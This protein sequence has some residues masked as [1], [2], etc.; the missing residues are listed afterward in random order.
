MKPIGILLMGLI[1]VYQ[2]TLA[3][4]LGANCRFEPSCSDYACR[5][6]HVHGAGR[7]SWLAIRRLARC[8]PWGAWGYDPVPEHPAGAKLPTASDRPA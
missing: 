6:I 5:A 1:R 8:H 2:W 4:V 7:G 3:P